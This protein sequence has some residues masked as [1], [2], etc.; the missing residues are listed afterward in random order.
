MP[1]VRIAVVGCGEA[2][3]RHHLPIL[4]RTPGTVVT[5]LVDPDAARRAVAA[6]YA[7]GAVLLADHR[8][9]A[10]RPDV[11]AV[12]LCLPSGLHA[13][14]ALAALDARKHVYVEKP[15]ATSLADA[16]RVRAAWRRAAVVGMMGFNYRWNRLYQ[17]ARRELVAG[18]L[19]EVLAVRTVFTI[20]ERPL[21]AWKRTRATGGGALYD[22]GAHHVDLVRFL[23]GE[24]AQVHADI[25]TRR[26]EAD[27]VFLQMHLESGLVVQSL[28]AFGVADEE[29]FEIHGREGTLTVDRSRHQ[30]A[31][32]ERHAARWR[33]LRRAVHAITKVAHARYVLEKR[34]VPG[35][36]PSHRIALGRFV[37]AVAGDGASIGPDLDDGYACV[38]VL[39]AAER[40]ARDGRAVAPAADA[41]AL[42]ET[43]RG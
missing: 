24:I 29:R 43:A 33:R 18:R 34:F 15:L 41:L 25:R 13:E 12:V 38:A 2:A 20:A 16:A 39:D 27:G 37:A 10:S 30:T 31:R 28:F 3:E 7:P 36:E 35:H 21:P 11:D 42:A 1:A 40:S 23:F 5:A 32:F 6:R 9:V 8:E 19:G 14:A 22:L 4:A 17:S 26:S